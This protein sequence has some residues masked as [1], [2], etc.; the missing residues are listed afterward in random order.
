VGPAAR[1]RAVVHDAAALDRSRPPPSG[2]PLD[3]SRPRS[4][5][6]RFAGPAVEDHIRLPSVVAPGRRRR[7]DPQLPSRSSSRLTTGSIGSRIAGSGLDASTHQPGKARLARHPKPARSS[8]RRARRDRPRLGREAFT[9]IAAAARQRSALPPGAS[10]SSVRSR[11]VSSGRPSAVPKRRRSRH[12]PAPGEARAGPQGAVASTAIASTIGCG[13]S[14]A[15]IATAA[16]GRRNAPRRRQSPP[17]VPA[18]PRQAVDGVL[19]QPLRA[20]SEPAERVT[21]RPSAA[22]CR[23]Y[24]PPGSTPNRRPAPACSRCRTT[25]RMPSNRAGP[26]SVPPTGI[27]RASARARRPN[28]EALPDAPGG[29]LLGRDAVAGRAGGDARTLS[30]TVARPTRNHQSRRATRKRLS[31]GLA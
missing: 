10:R 21:P 28:L 27:R 14:R 26:S 8:A 18:G 1:P 24:P 22:D 11:I 4:R 12:A 29:E 19:R 17:E 7:A 6:R 3:R 15:A 31:H 9:A 20:A 2:P 23:P 16:A 25:N 30:T 5:S 13:R